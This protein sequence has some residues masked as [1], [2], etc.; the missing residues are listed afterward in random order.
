MDLARA[1]YLDQELDLALAAVGRVLKISPQEPAAFTL[2][3][4]IRLKSG[5]KDLAR[6]AYER[7]VYAGGDAL[8]LT[9]LI[10]AIDRG[11]FDPSEGIGER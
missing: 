1:Y 2:L 3:G 5:Q 10:E 4:H 7:A 8:T 9:R 11:D 6:A